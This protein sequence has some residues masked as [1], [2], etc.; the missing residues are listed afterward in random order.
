[1]MIAAARIHSD[2]MKKR[3][4]ILSKMGA[5]TEKRDIDLGKEQVEFEKINVAKLGLAVKREETL[6]KDAEIKDKEKATQNRGELK[7]VK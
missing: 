5:A 7:V 6:R 4:D 2:E 3:A 1:M